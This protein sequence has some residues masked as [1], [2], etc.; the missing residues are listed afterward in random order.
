MQTENQKEN[1]RKFFAIDTEDCGGQ[2]MRVQ[3]I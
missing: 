3:E 2:L 1:K